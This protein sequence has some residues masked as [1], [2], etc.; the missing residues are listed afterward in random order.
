[1]P[2]YTSAASNPVAHISAGTRHNLA[3]T[4]SG[5]TYSWGLG[6]LEQ[7]GLGEGVDS[8]AIPTI[9]RSKFL[10]PYDAVLPTAGGQHCFVL[11]KKRAE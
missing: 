7:L 6:V 1:M 2:A 3:V 5:H 4:T 9:V 10:R 8:A 11:G